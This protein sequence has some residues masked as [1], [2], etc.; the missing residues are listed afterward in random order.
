MTELPTV[1]IVIPTLN[2]ELHIESVLHAC[3]DQ[4]YPPHLIDVIV[5][6]GGSADATVGIVESFAAIN[7]LTCLHNPDR[8]QS[9]G[10]NTAAA[11][12]NSEI[13]V[14]WDAHCRYPDNY[15][16]AAVSVLS[17]SGVEVVGGL[18]M[19]V[20]DS[21]IG[22][23][24]A[25]AMRS[26]LG[27]GT[28]RYSASKGRRDVDTVHCG[29]MRRTTFESVG[30]FD[31]TMRPAGEDVDL[32]YRILRGGGRI[33]LDP[34]IRVEYVT[35]ASLGAVARQYF[36]YGIAKANMFEKHRRL[37]SARPLAP[38]GLVAATTVGLIDR[39]TRRLALMLSGA[40]AASVV[41]LALRSVTGS[42]VRRLG[43][44]G[45]SMTMHFSYGSGMW[46]GVL[47]A[48]VRRSRYDRSHRHDG[49]TS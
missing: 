49:R 2:E 16:T 27:V 7:D 31:T 41:A 40:Y 17:E 42:F 35:R 48:G 30:G 11:L 33:V 38:A 5:V 10:L 20:G 43:A 15:V 8:H 21:L 3:V 13:L 28:D 25:G 46:V 19:P 22:D 24:A 39:R 32:S 47:R 29:A 34:S 26:R 6:D 9:A 23:W 12:S 37:P 36:G 14:R 4:D 45:V 44:A 1:T 18:W